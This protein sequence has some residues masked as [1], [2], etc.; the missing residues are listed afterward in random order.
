[1]GDTPVY[2][3]GLHSPVL[4]MGYTSVYENEQYSIFQGWAMLQCIGMGYTQLCRDG[5]Y[6]LM[7]GKAETHLER[8]GIKCLLLQCQLYEKNERYG[9]Q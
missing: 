6:S 9:T 2:M 3:N 1:M 4:G 8:K 7:Q 5:R